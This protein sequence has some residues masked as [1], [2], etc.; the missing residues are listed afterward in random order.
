MWRGVETGK[1]EL[2]VILYLP[3]IH[4]YFIYP[5]RKFANKMLF[6]II[7]KEDK[8]NPIDTSIVVMVRGRLNNIIRLMLKVLL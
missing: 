1:Y 4:Q 2:L 6:N 3:S 8:G 7:I 5:A